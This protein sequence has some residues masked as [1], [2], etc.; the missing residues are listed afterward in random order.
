MSPR[1]GIQIAKE[2]P[3]SPAKI[4]A[5]VAATLAWAARLDAL[6][7]G[8]QKHAPGKGRIIVLP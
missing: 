5:A 6:S 3:D 2:Y 8:F 1:A 4:D 7:A